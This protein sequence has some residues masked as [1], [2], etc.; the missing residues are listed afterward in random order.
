MT[1][2]NNDPSLSI[3]T[4]PCLSF[5]CKEKLNLSPALILSLIS[6]IVELSLSEIPESLILREFLFSIDSSLT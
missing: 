4:F 2:L 6:E 3:K 1:Y 5:A